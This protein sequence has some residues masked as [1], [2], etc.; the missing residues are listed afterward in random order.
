MKSEAS[1]MESLQNYSSTAFCIK[2]DTGDGNWWRTGPDYGTLDE[3]VGVIQNSLN[4][5]VGKIREFGLPLEDGRHMI[6]PGPAL[7]NCVF[8]AEEYTGDD[9]D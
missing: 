4:E 1:F 7:V 5:S 9:S 2:V 6:I 8:L 3:A